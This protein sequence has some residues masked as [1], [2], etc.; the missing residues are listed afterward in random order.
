MKHGFIRVA[1]AIPEIKVADCKFNCSKMIEM[2]EQ[3][4][5]DQ[6]EIISF[7]ELSITGY[8]CGDL[9]L[10]QQLLKDAENALTALLLASYANNVIVIV[11]MPLRCEQQ[12]YNVAVVFQSGKY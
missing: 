11:G 4:E 2:I 8:T 1:A 7:P 9:F 3:A 10:Q 6:V 12:L 5:R